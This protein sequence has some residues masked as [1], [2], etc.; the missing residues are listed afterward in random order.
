MNRI[1]R[2]LNL[3]SD[4][5]ERLPLFSQA[6][7]C[8]LPPSGGHCVPIILSDCWRMIAD[9]LSHESRA[10]HL[11]LA[12]KGKGF[13]VGSARQRFA[14]GCHNCAVSFYVHQ[15]SRAVRIVLLE[16][17]SILCTLKLSFVSFGRL[18]NSYCLALSVILLGG[19]QRF[20][21]GV[22]GVVLPG[23]RNSFF[24]LVV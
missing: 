6:L 24:V 14:L 2:F 9:C 7:D 23:K 16:R 19:R 15:T 20:C 1:S 4:S 13:F 12:R 11:G 17:S 22:L 3:R 10:G 8:Y 18:N 21:Y 5:K